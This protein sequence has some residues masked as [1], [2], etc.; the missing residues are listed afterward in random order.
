MEK[1]QTFSKE[2]QELDLVLF[3]IGTTEL[4]V[5][6]LLKLIIFM[7]LLIWFAARVQAWA[8]R[9]AQRHSGLD[10]GSQQAIGSVIRYIVLVAGTV[11][12]LQNIGINLT[13]FTM[14]AGA[15]GVGVGF[16]LQNV[17][18]NF[19]SGLIIMVERPIKVGDRVELANVEGT[20]KD[21]GARRTTIVT[22]DHVAILVPNQRFITD[23]VVSLAYQGS[24]IRLRIPVQVAAATDPALMKDLLLD[25]AQAHDE[26]LKSPAPQVLLTALGG[27]AT[28]FEL[29][30]WHS[31]LGMV[32]QQLFSALA[33]D[34]S[35][36]LRE[37]AIQRA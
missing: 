27:G 2:L 28:M 34:I 36:K 31:P 20:V 18:S 37:A 1:W 11:L 32:R 13:A 21:I 17:F 23:N 6:S 3:H 19:I 35:E 12:T 25:A 16:G 10:I 14:V 9:W 29:A 15:L 4:T 22:H 30:V 8:M 5:S 33:F 26:V 7:T 24:P